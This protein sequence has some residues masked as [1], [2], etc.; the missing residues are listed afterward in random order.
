MKGLPVGLEGSL[1]LLWCVI[2]ELVMEHLAALLITVIVTLAR[3]SGGFMI[4]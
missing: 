1:S 2:Q 3:L 4:V